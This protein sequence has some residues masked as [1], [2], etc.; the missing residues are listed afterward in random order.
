MLITEESVVSV[1]SS[2]VFFGV[3]LGN[4]SS[5]IGGG[6][7]RSS[8]WVSSVDFSASRL[9]HL[10][11]ASLA[12]ANL[13]SSTTIACKCSTVSRNPCLTLGSVIICLQKSSAFNFAQFSNP[14]PSLGLITAMSRSKEF[15]SLLIDDEVARVWRRASAFPWL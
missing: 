9:K 6:V 15:W 4:S 10:A 13:S 3:T 7:S 1:P 2:L 14:N 12:W 5:R 11:R 8:R